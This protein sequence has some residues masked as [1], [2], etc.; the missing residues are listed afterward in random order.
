M[1]YNRGS[2][3]NFWSFVEN[4]PAGVTIH[5]VDEGVD[6]GKIINQK[7][8]VFDLNHEKNKLT[9]RSTYKILIREI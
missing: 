4:T 9:F 7:Q 8:I 2:H 3:P 5:E 1:P 6:T